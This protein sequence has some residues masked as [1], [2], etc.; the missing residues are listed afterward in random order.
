MLAE[1]TRLVLLAA[2]FAAAALANY[3]EIDF[4]FKDPQLIQDAVSR[5]QWIAAGTFEVTYCLPWIDGWHC[6]GR[7]KTIEVLKA[8][9]PKLPPTLRWVER[10]GTCFL[11]TLLS[12][13]DGK[14]GVWFLIY[15][16]GEWSLSPAG[17]FCGGM[18]P[19]ESRRLVSAAISR[20]RSK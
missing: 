2:L 3:Q 11:C 4:D 18:F 10:Y 8:E 16:Q 6:G 9:G 15:R 14:Q 5:A 7:I 1:L 13:N 12:R 17:D 19:L 20:E